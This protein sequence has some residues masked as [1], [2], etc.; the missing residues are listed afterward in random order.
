M[1]TTQAEL[2]QALLDG[3]KLVY[4]YWQHGDFVHLVKGTTIDERGQSAAYSFIDPSLWSTCKEPMKKVK[5][6][7]WMN[8][9][10]SGRTANY[11][12]ASRNEADRRAGANR[13]ACVK[14]EREVE[15]GEGLKW[16]KIK[17]SG[18]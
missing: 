12:N 6:E 13:I 14:F 8:V 3:K 4:K 17:E 9:Y 7:F 15:E 11:C 1:F 16:V 5:M 10:P 18:G 2:Y